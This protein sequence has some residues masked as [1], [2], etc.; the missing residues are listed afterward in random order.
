MLFLIYFNWSGTSAE[1]KE[2]I[3]RF[4][5]IWDETEGI[6]FKDVYNTMGGGW[7]AVILLEGSWDASMKAWSTYLNKYGRPQRV[8]LSKAEI[9]VKRRLDV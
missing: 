6:E 9:L 7:N 3:D 5:V 2:Y 4:K 8:T 1:L